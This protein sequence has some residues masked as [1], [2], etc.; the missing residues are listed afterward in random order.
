MDSKQL[1]EET[2]KELMQQNDGVNPN[3]PIPIEQQLE[4]KRAEYRKML[5]FAPLKKRITHAMEVVE[6]PIKEALDI[7]A[8]EKL[9]VEL[10][11]AADILV[12]SPEKQGEELGISQETLD[13]LFTFAENK[14][15]EQAFDDAAAILTLLT[16]LD[17]SWFRHW[18]FLGVSLQE[19]NVL[20]EAIKAYEQ[21]NE[22]TDL[23]PLVHIFSAECYADLSDMQKAKLHLDKA[24]TIMQGLEPNPVWQERVATLETRVK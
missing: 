2:L 4:A 24:K 11:N 18:F 5:E 22:I 19:L 20:D 6:G 1:L 3:S 10:A 23:D 8:Y 21:A 16:V 14:L 15:K 17:R 7:E 12:E 13:T 9:G